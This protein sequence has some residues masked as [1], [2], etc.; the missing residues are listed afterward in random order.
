MFGEQCTERYEVAG[1]LFVLCSS[2][3]GANYTFVLWAHEV[4][5]DLV[6]CNSAND[7]KVDSTA[8]KCP[9]CGSLMCHCLEKNATDQAFSSGQL[10]CFLCSKFSIVKMFLT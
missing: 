9:L 2:L 4:I 8:A 3:L 6:S 7:K 5:V 10:F 1:V